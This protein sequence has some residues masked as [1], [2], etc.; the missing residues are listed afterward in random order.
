MIRLKARALAMQFMTRR[1]VRPLP[2]LNGCT[3]ATRNMVIRASAGGRV[4]QGVYP[5]ES[6]PQANDDKFRYD[7]VSAAGLIGFFFP[8]VTSSGIVSAL[9]AIP[10]LGRVE[11]SAFCPIFTVSV[12]KIPNSRPSLYAFIFSGRLQGVL[13]T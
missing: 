1:A 4:G 12:R 11:T 13:N 3:S 10:V 9:E 5:F 6:I 7:E 8:S 2:W